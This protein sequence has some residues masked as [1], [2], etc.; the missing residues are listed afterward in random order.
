M[1]WEDL[2]VTLMEAFK[3]SCLARCL[4]F[5]AQH[6][7]ALVQQERRALSKIW[8]FYLQRI[9][10][11]VSM[12]LTVPTQGTTKDEGGVPGLFE[13]R[14][15]LRCPYNGGYFQTTAKPG[16]FLPLYPYWISLLKKKGAF[17]IC[18]AHV[19]LQHEFNYSS[20]DTHHYFPPKSAATPELVFFVYFWC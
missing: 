6:R 15:W 20:L 3:A 16:F 11:I 14:R 18:S 5:K 9:V 2:G 19:N 17:S 8:C 4:K 1:Q 7:K 12:S 10:G 13:I